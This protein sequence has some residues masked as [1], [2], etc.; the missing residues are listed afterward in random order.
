MGLWQD[1]KCHLGKHDWKLVKT[2]MMKRSC[3][4]CRIELHE[5]HN[6]HPIKTFECENCGIQT[7]GVDVTV[8]VNSLDAVDLI[9][10]M[11]SGC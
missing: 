1:L 7:R 6:F 4:V 8:T 5:P 9:P 10:N 2:E 3:A 11:E